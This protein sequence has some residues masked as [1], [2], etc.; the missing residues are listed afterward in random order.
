MK[1]EIITLIKSINKDFDIYLKEQ[2]KNRNIPIKYKH[3]GLFAILYEREYRIEFKDLVKECN[4]SKSTLSETINK[5][6]EKGLLKK[7]TIS[8]D[9]RLAYI[10]LTGTGKSYSE[11]FKKIYK[12]YSIKIVKNL[13]EIIKCS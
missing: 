7:E 3:A 10:S 2:L 9:K 5:Y 13:R 8:V 1:E 4:I 12:D 6:V 11:G